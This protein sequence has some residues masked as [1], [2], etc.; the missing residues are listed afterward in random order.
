MYGEFTGFFDEIFTRLENYDH[1]GEADLI[2]QVR[3]GDMLGASGQARGLNA[4][5]ISNE[6]FVDHRCDGPCCEVVIDSPH[7]LRGAGRNYWDQ[8]WVND[9]NQD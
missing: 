9:G 1:A 8:G 3:S 5:H 4:L 6:T 7:R 2:A